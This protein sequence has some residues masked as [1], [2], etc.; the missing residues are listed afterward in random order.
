MRSSPMTFYHPKI[1]AKQPHPRCAVHV[2]ECA[3]I[4]SYAEANMQSALMF[5]PPTF[6]TEAFHIRTFSLTGVILLR[7]AC[8]Y[9]FR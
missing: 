2:N 1:K 3:L 6:D 7:P 9:L 4:I 8:K 5:S